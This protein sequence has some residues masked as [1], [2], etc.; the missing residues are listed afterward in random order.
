[1]F[2][3]IKYF[4]KLIQFVF[5]TIFT[6]VILVYATG[7]YNEWRKSNP[8]PYYVEN[9]EDIFHHLSKKIKKTIHQS[10]EVDSLLP[11]SVFVTNLVSQKHLSTTNAVALDDVD[12]ID[13][14]TKSYDKNL[15][16]L[17]EIQKRLE[18]KH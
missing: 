5:A 6:L 13:L 18:N 7:K 11:P 15:N 12:S 4:F 2:G 14:S 3:I 17:E 10:K 8:V 9:T 16:T 1:M